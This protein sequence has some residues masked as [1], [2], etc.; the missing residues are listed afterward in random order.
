MAKIKLGKTYRDSISKFEG[1]ATGI[2]E[3]LHG[4]RQVLLSGSNNGQPVAEWFD[5]QRIDGVESTAT[6]GGP[7]H[8]PTRTT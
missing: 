6:A 4:C 8:Q 3:Y 5:E 7:Q 1:T 2:A